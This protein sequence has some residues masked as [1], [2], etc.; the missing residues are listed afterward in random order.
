M[1]NLEEFGFVGRSNDEVYDKYLSLISNDLNDIIKANSKLKYYT[2]SHLFCDEDLKFS[3]LG[4]Y[5]PL[6]QS[7]L[8][9]G[10]KN[11]NIIDATVEDIEIFTKG[12][13]NLK[14][15]EIQRPID[16]EIIDELFQCLG[17]HK[18]LLAT[19]NLVA[20]D[21]DDNDDDNIIKASS[22]QCLFKGCPLL[23]DIKFTT[24][25][26]PAQS[27]A[28]VNVTYLNLK[29]CDILSNDVFADIGKMTNLKTFYLRASFT[30]TRWK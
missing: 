28:N 30:V 16:A 7:L 23:Q 9:D 12:C 25:N 14:H 8:I 19:L 1:T 22:F 3:N 20:I 21:Y 15:L 4:T 5:C 17:T 13:R 29:Y 27:F 11:Y 18:P 10:D 6:L 2:I 24:F 26:I